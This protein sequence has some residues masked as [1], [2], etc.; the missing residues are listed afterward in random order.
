MHSTITGAII[1]QKKRKK[2]EIFMKMK[3]DNFKIEREKA[4]WKTCCP[5]FTVKLK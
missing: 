3:Y 2:Q 1:V 5:S 4:Q